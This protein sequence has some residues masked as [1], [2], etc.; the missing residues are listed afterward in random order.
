MKNV[1]LAAGYATR[2]G[3]LT[4][5][6]PKPLLRIGESTILGRL[7]D[8]ID[9]IESIDEHIL[10]TNHKFEP[11]FRQWVAEQH[12]RKPIRIVD[13][14]S[15]NNDNRLGAVQ[16]L[17]YAIESQALDE[18]LLV[19]A[20]DNL[21]EF[22][23]AEFVAFAQEKQSSCVMCHQQP[24]IEKLRRTGVVELDDSCRI[25]SME[26]KPIT[27][28]TQWAVPPFYYYRREDLGLIRHA[29]EQGCKKDAPGNL[30]HYLCLHT[31]MYAWPMNGERIDIGSIDT[32]LQ[33]NESRH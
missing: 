1:I 12:Y 4:R 10:I 33:H 14:G 23:F 11:I 24:D 8:N 2:L 30:A 18:D 19:V 29:V 6:F 27:P 16:D 26:E 7:L 28:K 21:F 25:L 22:D 3:E 9:R 20:A 32:Y 5:D 31:D 15:T 13:D 17:L